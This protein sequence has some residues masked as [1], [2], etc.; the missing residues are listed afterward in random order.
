[1][2]PSI[3]HHF[4]CFYNFS[5]YHLFFL[6]ACYFMHS[7][8]FSFIP[9]DNSSLLRK[10]GQMFFCLAPKTWN[11]SSTMNIEVT[12]AIQHGHLVPKYYLNISFF[13]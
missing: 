8:I 4:L 1:M 3:N 10:V 2:A 5:V 6:K 11:N 13:S 7:G 9:V 12:V